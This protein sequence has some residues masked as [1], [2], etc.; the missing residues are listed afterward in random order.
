[1]CGAIEP[2]YYGVS[3]AP[4]GSVSTGWRVPGRFAAFGD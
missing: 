2:E 4:I 3:D 1:M